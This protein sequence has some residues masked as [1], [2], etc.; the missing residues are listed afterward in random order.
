GH[1]V[2]PGGTSDPGG[3]YTDHEFT[4]GENGPGNRPF[5]SCGATE[6]WTLPGWYDAQSEYQDLGIIQLDCEVGN[7]TG[8][9]GYFS[10]PGPKALNGLVTHLRGYPGDKPF[11]TMWTDRKQVRVTQADMVF[12]RND[13][14]GGQS[15]S[16]VF[17]WG[18]YCAGPCAM[19]IHG[20]GVGHGGTPHQVNNH[21]V[22]ISTAREALIASVAGQ[23]G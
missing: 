2:H 5:G 13:T 9:F 3:W 1:C 4:P 12:Y 10:R 8:W 20:Y 15:G 19:A 21:G 22:R 23:N 16:P 17:Q 18:P 7:E 14:F 6:L 11:G